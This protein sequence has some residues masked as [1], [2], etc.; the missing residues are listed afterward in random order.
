VRPGKGRR[1]YR[2]QRLAHGRWHSVGPLSLTNARGSYTRVVCAG[3]G[4][5][6]RIVAPTLAATSR[7]IVIH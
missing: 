5:S 7:R 6:F 2:L 3:R 4:A 1:W